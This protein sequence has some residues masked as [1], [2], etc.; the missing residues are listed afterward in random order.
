MDSEW[1]FTFSR[2]ETYPERLQEGGESVENVAG[3]DAKPLV[4]HWFYC[5]LAI[6]GPS[7]SESQMGPVGINAEIDESRIECHLISEK[8]E[9]TRSGILHF[10]GWKHTQNGCSWVERARRMLL[11][12]MQN[13][14]YFIGFTAIWPFRAL[15]AVK[16]QWI[17]LESMLELI[18]PE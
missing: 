11:G 13:Q 14:W 2:L 1:I 5:Y 7:G 10:L 8:V 3:V 18:I 15:Q 12:I 4:F 9:W 16:V 6:P 17:P